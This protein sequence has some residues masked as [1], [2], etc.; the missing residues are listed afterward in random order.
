MKLNFLNNAVAGLILSLSC[1]VSTA[2]AG[3]IGNLS[4]TTGD[5]FVT[6]SLNNLE[7]MHFDA[8]GST[9]TVA[10]LLAAF[11]DSNS[12]L[13]GFT[14]SGSTHADLFL[15]AAFGSNDYSTT[16]MGYAILDS[17]VDGLG[18]QNTIGDAYKGNKNSMWKYFG[19]DGVTTGA[20]S[21]DFIA[22]PP[23]NNNALK[24][25]GSVS[26]NPDSWKNSM[27]WLAYRPSDSNSITPPV[28]PV[29]APTTI[30]VF[31]LALLGFGSRRF[32]KKS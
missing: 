31:A 29:P 6:D 15:D 13:Y 21:F 7:W 11:S 12:E 1:L 17:N 19:D 25:N 32:K 20:I 18:L 3:V 10:S 22:G 27:S 23:S 24:H 16:A 9:G 8:I 2:N 28:V 4:H 26:N 30:T 5:A 14:L